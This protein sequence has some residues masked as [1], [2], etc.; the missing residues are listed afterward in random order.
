MTIDVFGGPTLFFTST[1]VL[2]TVS[3]SSEYPFDEVQLVSTDTVE[4]DDNPIGFN[5]GGSLTYR[6]TPTF[7]AAFQARY[8]RASISLTPSGG[9]AIELDAGGFRVGGGIRIAF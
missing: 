9:N 7:G 1:Q 3:S 8:S 6:F 4:L 2:S 5:V